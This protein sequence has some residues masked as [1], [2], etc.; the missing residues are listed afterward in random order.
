MTKLMESVKEIER[1][2]ENNTTVSH[3]NAAMAEQMTKQAQVLNM[4][5]QKFRL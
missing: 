4:Q 5:M 1:I 3:D 2:V